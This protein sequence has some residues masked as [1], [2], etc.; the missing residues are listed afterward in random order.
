MSWISGTENKMDFI[1]HERTNIL[2]LR[3]FANGVEIFSDYFL[4]KSLYF[5]D[6]KNFGIRYKV[7]SWTYS[8]LYI[9]VSKWGTYYSV[10]WEEQDEDSK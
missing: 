7:Y 6:I 5:D 2:P 1:R 10:K 9:P 8:V 3:W 4:K